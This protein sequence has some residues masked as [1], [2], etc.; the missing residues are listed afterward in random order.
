MEVM[1]DNDQHDPGL[2]PVF[3]NEQTGR[4]RE[5]RS[6]FFLCFYLIH[7]VDL[8]YS[9]FFFFSFL[10][11]DY[12]LGGLGDSYYEYL[13]KQWIQTNKTE[14]RFKNWYDESSKVNPILL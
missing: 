12:A 8:S 14:N 6:F 4:G 7:I 1:K 10:P 2:Y 5:A 3:L 9:F 13:L 11:E